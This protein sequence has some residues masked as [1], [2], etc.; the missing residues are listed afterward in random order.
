MFASMIAHASILAYA[1]ILFP[2][3]VCLFNMFNVSNLQI[4]KKRPRSRGWTISNQNFRENL[5]AIKIYHRGCLTDNDLPRTG[6]F[7]FSYVFVIDWYV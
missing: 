2:T 5:N 7:C 3:A 4:K 1:H 6:L